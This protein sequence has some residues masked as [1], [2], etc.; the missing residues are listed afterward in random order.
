V[1]HCDE[2]VSYIAVREFQLT[3]FA[4]VFLGTL[5]SSILVCQYSATNNLLPGMDGCYNLTPVFEW[6]NRC[7]ISIFLVFMIAFMPLF[8]QGMHDLLFH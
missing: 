6:I 8:I 1:L 4:V 5:N 7:I 3:W 2:Y